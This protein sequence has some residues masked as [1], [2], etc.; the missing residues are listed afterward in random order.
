MGLIQ[1]L[2]WFNSYCLQCIDNKK[3]FC[4]ISNSMYFV[5]W[6]NTSFSPNSRHVSVWYY[7][8]PFQVPLIYNTY[9]GDESRTYYVFFRICPLYLWA[10]IQKSRF[11]L[12][13]PVRQ[14]I[15]QLFF[16]ASSVKHGM[17]WFYL[18]HGSFFNNFK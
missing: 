6:W 18:L 7:L 3:H 14:N 4:W 15:F 11:S 17:I 8:N 5:S 2:L 13:K 10:V 12:N 9:T 1:S 16:C